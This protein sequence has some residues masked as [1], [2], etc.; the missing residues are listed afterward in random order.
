MERGNPPPSGCKFVYQSATTRIEIVRIWH[1]RVLPW[2]CSDNNR[3]GILQVISMDKAESTVRI[4]LQAVEAPRYDVGV[5]SDR[6]MLPGL[7]SIEAAKVLSRLS[8]SS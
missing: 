5:L 1:D 7:E 6:G 3:K 4:M 2:L 8:L